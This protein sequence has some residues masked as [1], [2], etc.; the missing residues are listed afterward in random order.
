MQELCFVSK[1]KPKVE[2]ARGVLGGITIRRIHYHNDMV[3][4]RLLSADIVIV[5]ICGTYQAF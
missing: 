4:F 3:Y 1:L 2:F 5:G